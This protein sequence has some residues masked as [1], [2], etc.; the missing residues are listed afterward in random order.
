[1]ILI[2]SREDDPCIPYVTP[3][4]DAAAAEYL[5]FNPA[6]FPADAQLEI[7]CDRL[8]RAQRMLRYRGRVWDLRDVRAV[9]LRR[10][11]DPMPAAELIGDARRAWVARESRELLDGL[12]ELLDCL[13]VPGQPRDVHVRCNKASDLPV[14]QRLGFAVPRTLITNSPDEALRFYSECGGRIVAKV[15]FNPIVPRDDES[16]FVYTHVVRRRDMISHRR[17]RHAPVILQEYIPKRAELR[18]TVVGAHVFAA[19]IGSQASRRTRHDWRRYDL[20]RTPHSRHSL[21]PAVQASCV[22]LVAAL[23]LCFAAIDMIVTPEGEYVFLEI[24]PNGEWAWIQDLTGLPIGDAIA[25]LLIDGL[26]IGGG[27]DVARA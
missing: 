24:N 3:R 8:G 6:R 9:W 12:W 23:G 16:G 21:P 13:W 14:A 11:Q 15:M 1:V 22:R 19:E 26:P 20:S 7:A 10:P 5:W 2:L 17:I 27:R 25:Q 18:I 4:L